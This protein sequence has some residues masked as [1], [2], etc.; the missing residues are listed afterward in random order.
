MLF[1]MSVEIA[2]TFIT[3]KFILFNGIVSIDLLGLLRAI[4]LSGRSDLRI[5][6]LSSRRSDLRIAILFKKVIRM[7]VVYGL[8]FFAQL[9]V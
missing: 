9:L 1:L 3:H 2:F 6:I 7:R 4:Q 5:A 8:Q